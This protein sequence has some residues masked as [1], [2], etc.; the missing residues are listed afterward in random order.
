MSITRRGDTQSALWGEAR[1][2]RQLARPVTA[3][4]AGFVLRG[5]MVSRPTS[6]LD[7]MDGFNH[8]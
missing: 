1:T 6:V 5:W 7:W 3:G 4:S 8:V 2:S